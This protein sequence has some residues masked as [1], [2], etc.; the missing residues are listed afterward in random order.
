MDWGCSIFFVLRWLFSLQ[1][2]TPL[3]SLSFSTRHMPRSSEASS[4]NAPGGYA[5]LAFSSRSSLFSR[6]TLRCFVHTQKV[7]GHIFLSKVLDWL[8]AVVW[9]GLCA[10]LWLL[11]HTYINIYSCERENSSNEET[12][13]LWEVFGVALII[14]NYFS[15]M[16]GHPNLNN[17]CSSSFFWRP[18]IG[19]RYQFHRPKSKRR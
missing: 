6:L 11:L 10:G 3:P 13:V 8:F 2:P 18:E 16:F 5:N 19:R 14:S 12:R 7:F 9:A 4:R 15:T 1:L 17:Y